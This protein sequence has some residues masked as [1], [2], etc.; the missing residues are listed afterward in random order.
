MKK[1]LIL[2][3]V[4]LASSL[5]FHDDLKQIISKPVVTIDGKELL[6]LNRESLDRLRGSAI[7]F[8]PQDPTSALS[9]SMRVGEQ[10]TEVLGIHGVTTS[11]KTARERL[12][13]ELNQAK[14][15]SAMSSLGYI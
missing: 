6:G 1:I 2:I 8:V 14:M 10:V 13:E 5:Y 9:P 4:V 15:N 12:K 3:I 11:K 7:S